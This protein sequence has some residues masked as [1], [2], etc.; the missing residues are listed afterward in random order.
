MSSR[1]VTVQLDSYV[2]N[3]WAGRDGSLVEGA[4]QPY[5]FHVLPDGTVDDVADMWRGDPARVI[6]FTQEYEDRRLAIRWEEL[7]DDPQ[8][9]VG[10]WLVTADGAGHWATHATPVVSIEVTEAPE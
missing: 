9:A 8:R 4:K 7:A 3:L 6:G 2:D 1:L 10:L 5:P